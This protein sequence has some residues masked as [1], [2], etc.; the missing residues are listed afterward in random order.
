MNFH[1]IRGSTP[2]E[3]F[4]FFKQRPKG[5]AIPNLAGSA[6]CKMQPGTDARSTGTL[7]SATFVM[8]QNI[9]QQYGDRFYVVVLAQRRWAGEE[10]LRQ[11]YAITVELKHEGEVRLYQ[12]LRQRA[13][14]Q[15]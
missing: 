3:I 6:K 5:E 4:E 14:I 9:A 15:A 2:E 8:K 12:P 13:R 1:L 10:I 11:R 7:Q